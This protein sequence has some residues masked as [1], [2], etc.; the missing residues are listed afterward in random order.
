MSFEIMEARDYC[1]NPFQT[2]RRGV[3]LAA[4]TAGRVNAMAV[5]WGGFGAFWG[6]DVVF[7]AVR[8]E[9]FTFELMEAADTFSVHVMPEGAAFDQIIDYCGSRSGRHEDKIAACG[10]TLAYEGGTPY[11]LEAQEVFLCRKL[12]RPQLLPKDFLPGNRILE[13]WYG[14]GFHHLYMGEITRILIRKR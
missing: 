10:L 3:L 4:E 2:M 13:D 7:M 14:G 12:A 1:G 6:R 5:G 9:R 8:P 11:F